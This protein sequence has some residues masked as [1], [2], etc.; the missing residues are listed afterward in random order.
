VREEGR[1]EDR[2]G[3]RRTFSAEYNAETVRSI[4]RLGKSIGQVA[5]EVG[6]GESP[7]R[8]W[9]AQ[10]EIAKPDG[11]PQGRIGAASGKD[12]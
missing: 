4:Q 1:V 2:K 3:K 12:W 9:V 7:L 11:D 10:A 8:R 5:L 6:I